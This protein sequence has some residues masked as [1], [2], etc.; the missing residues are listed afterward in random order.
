MNTTTSIEEK[1]KKESDQYNREYKQNEIIEHQ[2]TTLKSESVGKYK[3]KTKA[4]ERDR[5]EKCK[6]HTMYNITM[7]SFMCSTHVIHC[8]K[9]KKNKKE[10]TEE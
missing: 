9:R 2:I 10:T 7:N 6:T 5:E 8:S 4:N 1:K 3:K